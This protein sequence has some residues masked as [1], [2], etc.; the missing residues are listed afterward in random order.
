M[1]VNLG[2]NKTVLIVLSSTTI[3]VVIIGALAMFFRRR[4]KRKENLNSSEVVKE[5]VAD[6][7]TSSK[8]IQRQDGRRI[9]RRLYSINSNYFSP[10]KDSDNNGEYRTLMCKYIHKYDI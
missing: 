6:E 3:G 1:S 4:K 2:R 10:K 8:Y 9:R 7:G 5:I